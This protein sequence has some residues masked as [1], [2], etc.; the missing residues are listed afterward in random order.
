[1]VFCLQDKESETLVMSV[2]LDRLSNISSECSMFPYL[3][4]KIEKLLEV[5]NVIKLYFW[6]V[7]NFNSLPK[8]TF[9][10]RCVNH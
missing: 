2:G 4:R 6:Y 10:F 3:Y 9:I 1:M 8:M 5:S 7:V